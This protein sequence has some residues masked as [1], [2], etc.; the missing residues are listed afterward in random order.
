MLTFYYWASSIIMFGLG[1]IWSKDSIINAI[2]KI[3]LIL[4]G[5]IGFLIAIESSFP[6]LTIKII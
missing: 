3:A 4:I 1:V 5:I 2:L 6:D